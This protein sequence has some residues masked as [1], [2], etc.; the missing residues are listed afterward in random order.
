[1]Q[2]AVQA[3]HQRRGA[4]GRARE[5]HAQRRSALAAREAALGDRLPEVAEAAARY[6]VAADR[7]GAARVERESARAEHDSAR[8]RRDRADAALK[9][10]QERRRAGDDAIRRHRQDADG[11]RRAAEAHADALDPARRA[12][13]LASPDALLRRLEEERDGLV[14]APARLEHLRAAQENRSAWA[15]E[16]R[17]HGEAA[18]RVPPEH[19]VP[20]AEAAV[21]LA[22]AEREAATAQ[23]GHRSLQQRLAREE[24]A[25][26]MAARLRH[27]GAR[28]ERR[29]AQLRR[30][31]QYLDR[32]HLQ[33]LLVKDALTTVVSHANAFL[34][35]LTGGSLQLVLERGAVD[36][37]E[38][39][40]VDAGSMREARSV[41]VLSGSQ[42]FRCAVAIASGIGQYAGAGGMRSIVIDEGFGSLDRD[43][44]QA[45]ITELKNLAEHMDRVVVVSHLD[46][47]TNQDHFPDQLRVIRG[48][49]GSRIERVL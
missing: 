35:R 3:L 39:K 49:D 29:A 6:G 30:L 11:H 17:V 43:G 38:V 37:F 36:E 32:S 48:G 2:E 45:I 14:D 31:A 7:L 44:Q 34:D 25:L 41:R 1:V 12:D 9:A 33:G 4:L 42:K 13:A 19:R 26:R 23:E 21:A 22:A 10:D 24:E 47:F 28:A 27:D 5:T 15:G 46:A 18:E 20:E 16:R 40:A 8:D